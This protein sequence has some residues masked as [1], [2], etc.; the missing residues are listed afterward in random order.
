ERRHERRVGA[1]LDQALAEMLQAPDPARGD[2]RDR[3]RLGH[4]AGQRDVVPGAGAV[5]VHAREQNLAR[6]EPL[7]LARPL[8]R[9]APG[10][11]AAAVGED[12]PGGGATV[13]FTLVFARLAFG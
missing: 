12:L 7:D 6:A 5:A 10:R 11:A 4:R 1:A 8:D 3:H 2:D 9:V 13:S